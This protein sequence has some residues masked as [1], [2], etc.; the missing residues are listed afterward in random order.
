LGDNVPVPECWFSRRHKLVLGQRL[1]L[2][3]PM[4]EIQDAPRF[5]RKIRIAWKDPTTVLPR[6]DRIL[7]KPAPDRALTDGG[8]QSRSPRFCAAISATL[9]RDS[10]CW[11]LEGN[12]QASAFT[13]TTTSGGKSPGP[14]RALAFFQPRQAFLKEAFP[15]QADDL[16][17]IIQTLG[18]FIIRETL[19][20]QQN[21]LG[22]H[23]LKIR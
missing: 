16:P 3:D 23:D 6:P 7:V 8:P 11:Q 22:A 14:S 20:C 17:A 1:A 13:W 15:P 9:Q 2:P 5:S 12:S 19:A 4:I 10:G 18:D 21:H